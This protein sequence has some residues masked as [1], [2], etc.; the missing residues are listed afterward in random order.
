MNLGNMGNALKQESQLLPYAG[1]GQE[2]LQR[3][4]EFRGSTGIAQSP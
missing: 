4:S 3:D 2:L 1:A